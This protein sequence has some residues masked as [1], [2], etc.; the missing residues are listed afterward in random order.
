MPK[1]ILDQS[2][3]K[4]SLPKRFSPSLK[5]LIAETG[6]KVF[7]NR[8][9]VNYRTGYKY[10]EQ[11]PSGTVLANYYPDDQVKLFKSVSSDFTTDLEDRRRDALA[12]LRRRGKGPP[13]KGQGKRATRGKK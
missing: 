13:T 4:M 6:R 11:K 2:C 9:Q 7:G 12:R 1:P 10:L 5:A 8:P 3:L